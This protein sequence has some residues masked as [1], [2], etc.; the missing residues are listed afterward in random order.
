MAAALLLAGAALA[1]QPLPEPAGLPAPVEIGKWVPPTWWTP[2]QAISGDLDRDG[3]PDLFVVLERRVFAPEQPEVPR[4]TRAVQILFGMPGATKWRPGP[5]V[6]GLLPCAD[7]TGGLTGLLESALFDLG[8]R[9]DGVL[10]VGWISRHRRGETQAVR[11]YLGWDAQHRQL[12]LLADD[13]LTEA[14]DS[15]ARH[16]R[17]RDFVAGRQWL[18]GL[19][20]P[21][22]PAFIPIEEVSAAAY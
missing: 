14:V 20:R 9:D 5:L 16:R 19:S 6:P 13:V 1:A 11:L 10:E 18:D 22:S 17:R 8:M 7:C 15:G 2:T 21:L 3:L 4:G 12:A